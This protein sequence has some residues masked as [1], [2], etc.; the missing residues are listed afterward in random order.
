MKEDI[1]NLSE[2]EKRTKLLIENITLDKYESFMGESQYNELSE[3]IK[4]LE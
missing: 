1:A 4:S 2:E 3:F